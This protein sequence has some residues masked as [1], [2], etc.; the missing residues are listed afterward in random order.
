MS[1]FFKKIIAF[2]SAFVLASIVIAAF[3]AFV[4]WFESPATWDP[5]NRFFVAFFVVGGG[6]V[7][8]MTA[9]EYAK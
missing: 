5:V 3:F 2:S 8:G 7:A 6:F 4:S 1:K 9:S